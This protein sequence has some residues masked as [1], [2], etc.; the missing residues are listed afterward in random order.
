MST[1]FLLDGGYGMNDREGIKPNSLTHPHSQHLLA[2]L[3]SQAN[4]RHGVQTTA[5]GTVNTP[6][7]KA[8]ATVVQATSATPGVHAGGF[9]GERGVGTGR[10][11]V[12]PDGHTHQAAVKRKEGDLNRS[13]P[14]SGANGRTYGG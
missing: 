10:P 2:T 9:T 3:Q 12:S 6:A 5:T 8:E 11:E 1:Q 4:S 13:I 14:T 7:M